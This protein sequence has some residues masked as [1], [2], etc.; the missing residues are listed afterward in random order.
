MS[1]QKSFTFYPNTESA[2]DWVVTDDNGNFVNNASLVLTLYWGRDKVRPDLVPGVPVTNVNSISMT[3]SSGNTYTGTFTIS[4]LNA[5][6]GGDYTLV[7][8]A[9]INS[10]PI[11]HWERPAVV[12]DTGV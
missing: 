3:L 9:T 1:V 12:V 6:Q 8:E 11:G 10:N 2:I 7:V 5:P 4:S